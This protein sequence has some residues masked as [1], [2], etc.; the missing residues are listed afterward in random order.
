MEAKV[1]E[2]KDRAE[3]K[4]GARRPGA[5]DARSLSFALLC[6]TAAGL[7][8]L[9]CGCSGASSGRGQ[10][11]EA[12]AT[13]DTSV[14]SSFG[15]FNAFNARE[16]PDFCAHDVDPLGGRLTLT[17]GRDP[18]LVE[19]EARAP[20]GEGS[21]GRQA[22]AAGEDHGSGRGGDGDGGGGG[23]AG[24]LT[25]GAVAMGGPDGGSGNGVGQ[26]DSVG[27]SRHE[28]MH[29]VM[30]H[31]EAYHEGPTDPE[32]S[33]RAFDLPEQLEVTPHGHQVYLWPTL[34]QLVA[35][36]EGHGFRLTLA[37]NPQWADSILADAAR[38]DAVKRWRAFG[39]EI[40]MHHHP[41][42]HPDWNGYTNDAGLLGHE[43]YL[44]TVSEGFERVQ[45]L[46][47]PAS[48]N[49]A[50]IGGL[51]GDAP[52]EAWRGISGPIILTQGNQHDSFA[53]GRVGLGSL[54]PTTMAKPAHLN[55]PGGS[56]V[57]LRHRELGTN[58]DRSISEAI[59][60]FKG[61]YS[62]LASEEVF[63]LVFHAFD[64]H[65][66]RDEIR[67]WFEFVVAQGG[68]VRTTTDIVARMLMSAR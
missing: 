58:T 56:V 40:A 63:G 26:P 3:A 62:N 37:M 13:I 16:Y 51:P 27:E 30:V 41:F 50:M 43:L 21:L 65:E 24:A 36:A 1:I 68:T 29:F 46:V 11:G 57:W 2:A 14:A 44:G 17:L 33:T 66:A 34:Q 22:Q 5:A 45:R 19:E 60:A 20:A 54:R 12:P 9:A 6:A 59:A 32:F 7:S 52:W 35:D 8:T 67:P 53:D 64:Y 48:L 49:T 28:R 47:A 4:R 25:A 31:L 15:V 18:L 61:Q 55:D 10:A 38:R 23:G 42:D 39:H